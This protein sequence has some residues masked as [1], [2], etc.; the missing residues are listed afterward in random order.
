MVA[1][2][3]REREAVAQEGVTAQVA[4]YN[5][6]DPRYDCEE[7]GHICHLSAIIC[8]CESSRRKVA[9]LRHA[10]FLCPCP[11]SAKLLVTWYTMEVL[12]ALLASLQ[13]G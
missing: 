9:C 10:R 7:C 1:L 11:P 6:A 4:M 5:D 12:Y 2:E 3:Q 13:A 8:R